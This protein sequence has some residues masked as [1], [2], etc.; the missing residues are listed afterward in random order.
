MKAVEDGFFVPAVS[1]IILAISEVEGVKLAAN[2]RRCL[3]VGSLRKSQ[4]SS[5]VYHIGEKD[6]DPERSEL[7]RYFDATASNSND[8]SM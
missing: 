6:V 2:E 7:K 3:V 4:R 8:L 1:F 5:P